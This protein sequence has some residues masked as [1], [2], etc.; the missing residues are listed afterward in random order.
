MSLLRSIIISELSG[1]ASS[2]ALQFLLVR[3][4]EGGGGRLFKVGHS[5]TL[6]TYRVG[7]YLRW[8]PIQGFVLNQ[9]NTVY[10]VCLLYEF[11]TVE[12]NISTKDKSEVT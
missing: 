2:C 5:L 4:R 6:P 9:I 12:N 8:V 10:V 3:V 11:E 7:A 1:A